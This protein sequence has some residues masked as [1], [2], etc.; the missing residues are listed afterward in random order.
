MNLNEDLARAIM[1]GDG[2]E[3]GAD[4]K[5][6]EDHIRPIWLDDDLYTIHVD[7]DV[8]A[9]KKELQGTNT[10]NTVSFND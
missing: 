7:L 5:I 4:D 8:A 9:A 1:I 3:E 10:V 6:A 2:R